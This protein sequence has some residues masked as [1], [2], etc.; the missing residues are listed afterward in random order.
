MSI[1]KRKP[2]KT[3]FKQKNKKYTTNRIYKK[4]SARTVRQKVMKEM[5][6]F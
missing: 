4:C 3:R 2:A 1:H 6:V 5:I